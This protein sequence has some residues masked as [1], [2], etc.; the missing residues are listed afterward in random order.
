MNSFLAQ[1]RAISMG[2]K[3]RQI[4]ARE[5]EGCDS[6]AR[7]Y[8]E[9][10]SMTQGE[11]F[12]MDLQNFYLLALG[13]GLT[14]EGNTNQGK[15]IG[16]IENAWGASG[17]Y[18]KFTAT[19]DT[20]VTFYSSSIPEHT[21]DTQRHH[22]VIF[23]KNWEGKL[24]SSSDIQSWESQMVI[25]ETAIFL[26]PTEITVTYKA[27]EGEIGGTVDQYTSIENNEGTVKGKSI[28]ISP[29]VVF[30]RGQ[31]GKF[32]ASADIT[33]SVADPPSYYPDKIFEVK[34]SII[35]S[36][37]LE[38]YQFQSDDEGL[39]GGEIAGIVIAC[40]VV[41]G[42]VAFCIVWFVVLKKPCP[43]GGKDAA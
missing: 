38:D 28:F 25:D 17:G 19:K 41:V 22:I 2:N 37:A 1:K 10:T 21:S 33:S 30:E 32:E 14:I 18:Y 43:C 6:C 26:S 4:K 11:C 13:D 3:T 35:F 29:S 12:C 23:K 7:S 5:P 36:S 27:T 15:Q 9:I 34:D 16:P 42:V 24:K 20:P 31:T 39:S 8:Y 40:V